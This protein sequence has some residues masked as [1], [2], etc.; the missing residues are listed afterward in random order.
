MSYRTHLEDKKRKAQRQQEVF[1]N[2][3]KM[4]KQT[5]DKKLCKFAREKI[6]ELSKDIDNFDIVLSQISD[7]DLLKADRD[8]NCRD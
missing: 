7:V 3:A 5:G 2:Q 4:A 1:K 6:A 8:V